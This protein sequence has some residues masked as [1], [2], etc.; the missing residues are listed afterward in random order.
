MK[1]AATRCLVA[2]SIFALA[3]TANAGQVKPSQ[4]VV[5]EGGAASG[6]LGAARASADRLQSIGCLSDIGNA[7]ADVWANCY[8]TDAKGQ[9]VYCW[10]DDPRMVSIVQSI[11]PY[12]FVNFSWDESTRRCSSVRVRNVSDTLP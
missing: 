8:A 9:Y 3:A 4:Q 6:S 2:L 5:I 11:T 1:H 10:T 12:S 7:M